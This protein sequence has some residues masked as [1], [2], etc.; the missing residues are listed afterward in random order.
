MFIVLYFLS[1]HLRFALRKLES[2]L[3]DNPA[4]NFV[5]P[6]VFNL[7]TLYDLSYSPDVSSNKKKTIQKV[8]VYYSIEEVNWRSFRLA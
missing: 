8:A 1:S 2:I 7:C 6:I 5:D 3:Q 4:Q